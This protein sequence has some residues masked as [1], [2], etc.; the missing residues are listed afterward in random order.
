MSAFKNGDVVVITQMCGHGIRMPAV[1]T[2]V[3]QTS[4]EW[5]TV[6]VK[7]VEHINDQCEHCNKTTCRKEE[8]ERDV[9]VRKDW[10]KPVDQTD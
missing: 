5:Y 2:V 9:S 6:H 1:G 10:M 3:T 8:R 4:E 7:W